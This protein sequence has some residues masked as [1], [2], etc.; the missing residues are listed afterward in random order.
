VCSQAG[1]L[2]CVNGKAHAH[3]AHSLISTRAPKSE[4]DL[5]QMT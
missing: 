3:N 1:H 2:Y 4:L 5:G